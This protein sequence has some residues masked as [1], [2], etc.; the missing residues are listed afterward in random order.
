MKKYLLDNRDLNAPRLASKFWQLFHYECLVGLSRD[1]LLII[2]TIPVTFI[3]HSQIQISSD[4][5]AESAG[6]LSGN[7]ISLSNDGN[8]V[9]FNEGNGNSSDHVQ[10]HN[11]GTVLISN[12]Y[13]LSQFSIYPNP[14][15]NTLHIK[16][17]TS[18]KLKKATLYNVLGQLVK[19]Q[20]IELID[21]SK[22][23]KGLYYVQV[24]TDQGKATKKISIE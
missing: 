13:V 16:L 21:V 12:E 4:I 2:F 11:L 24:L 22:L 1:S 20:T 7:S 19:E 3:S 6:D 9:P 5:V 8:I 17:S 23:S 10:V 14:A 15:V 18:L